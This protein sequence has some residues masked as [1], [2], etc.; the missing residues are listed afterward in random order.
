MANYILCGGIWI[1]G[2]YTVEI[3]VINIYINSTKL[4]EVQMDK[5]QKIQ[6]TIKNGIL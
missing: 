6:D 4:Y 1:L 5:A 3:T 2:R